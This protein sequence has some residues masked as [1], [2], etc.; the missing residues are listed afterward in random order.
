MRQTNHRLQGTRYVLNDAPSD[1]H[2]VGSTVEAASRVRK[3]FLMEC[4]QHWHGHLG[5][6]S[7]RLVLIGEHRE[8]ALDTSQIPALICI[9]LPNSCPSPALPTRCKAL[10]PEP[11]RG[12]IQAFFLARAICAGNLALVRVLQL[13]EKDRGDFLHEAHPADRGQARIQTFLTF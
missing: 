8:I 12:W 1:G 2:R 13:D 4:R 3:G 11:I 6:P 5:V 7:S 10:E 9:G